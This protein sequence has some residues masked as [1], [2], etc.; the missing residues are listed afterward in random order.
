MVQLHQLLERPIPVELFI[1]YISHISNDS[2]RDDKYYVVNINSFKKSVVDGSLAR[3]CEQIRP[4][5]IPGKRRYT[6]SVNTYSRF[7]TVVRQMCRVYG[8]R[9]DKI[10]NASGQHKTFYIYHVFPE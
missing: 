7:L 4:F 5:Y 10:R 3:Y 9:L 8:M 6:E 2:V 1:A